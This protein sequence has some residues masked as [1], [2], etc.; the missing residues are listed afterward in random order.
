MRLKD[1]S[2]RDLFH[3]FEH[4]FA[5]GDGVHLAVA[6]SGGGDSIALLSLLSEWSVMSGIR[7]S[8]VTVDHGIR[9]E[10]QQEHAIAAATSQRLSIDHTLLHWNPTKRGN[11][12]DQARRARYRLIADWAKS[13]GIPSVALA[14]TADDQAETVLMNLAR[15]SGVDGLS[16]MPMELERHD[17]LWLRPLLRTRRK[18]LRAYLCKRGLAWADDPSNE[19]LNF[20]RAKFRQLL[21]QSSKL[22]LSTNRLVATSARMQEARKVL[23]QAA[24]HAARTCAVRTSL[25]EVL[26]NDQFWQFPLDTRMRLAADAL[27]AVSGREYRPRYT[28]LMNALERVQRFTT[29]ISGCILTPMSAGGFLV[30]REFAACGPPV[31]ALEVWDGR[32][33]LQKSDP[34]SGCVIA[35]LGSAGRDRFMSTPALWLD[36]EL[37]A[38]PFAGIRTEW[39]FEYCNH[40]PC[41]GRFSQAS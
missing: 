22:G 16:A 29:T 25:G 34:P 3:S 30:M 6:V 41:W 24:N 8:A 31:D 35:G 7:L 13:N 36:G 11:L 1:N 26:F 28:S 21:G 37:W 32:W 2:K 18:S 15:G 40:G 17:T 10:A 4:R 33:R 14:H 19:N 38:S 12:Q 39:I 20:D 23:E 27:R 5:L 9:P